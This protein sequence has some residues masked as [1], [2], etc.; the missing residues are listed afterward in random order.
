MSLRISKELE[1]FRIQRPAMLEKDEPD[2][3]SG[4]FR[5]ETVERG[6]AGRKKK[7]MIVAVSTLEGWEHASVSLA[8]RCPT[9]EEMCRVK[10]L[11][12]DPEDA[13][14]Q[15][16]PPRSQYVNGMQTCL[17]MWRPKDGAG[18]QMIVPPKELVGWNAR[19][20]TAPGDVR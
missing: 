20:V 16:H 13:V 11:L 10:D 4:F 8:H 3:T 2:E 19:F 18:I 1:R 9:W 5:L 15:Y 6:I 14:V 17:H 7:R 12:W